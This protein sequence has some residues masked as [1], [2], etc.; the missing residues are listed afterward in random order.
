MSLLGALLGSLVALASGNKLGR[1]TELMMASV[2]YGE[3]WMAPH[4]V[5]AD[6]PVLV[7]VTCG[8][9][10]DKLHCSDSHTLAVG[11]LLPL[12]LAV[13]ET[14]V[15]FTAVLHPLLQVLLLEVWV[16][17]AVWLLCW[18]VECCMDWG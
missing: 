6:L 12:Q 1:R 5:I 8:D 9:G 17:Q 7:I 15:V 16:Y 13:A 3:Y 4:P 11:P 2:L 14:H 10:I 18:L